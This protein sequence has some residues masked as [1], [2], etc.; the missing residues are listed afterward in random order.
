MGLEPAFCST[1]VSKVAAALAL[2]KKA[3]ASTKHITDR[4]HQKA[5]TFK[6]VVSRDN[7]GDVLT[8]VIGLETMTHLAEI[9]PLYLVNGGKCKK[10]THVAIGHFL[11]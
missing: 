1:T 10:S 11:S 2:N 9:I 7:L 5:I 8:K 4:V 6:Q 3:S